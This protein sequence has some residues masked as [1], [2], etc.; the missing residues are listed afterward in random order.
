MRTS[1][2]ERDGVGSS[3][4]TVA[5]S[6]VSGETETR[7]G[8]GTL[9]EIPPHTTPGPLWICGTLI[10]FKDGGESEITVLHQ[11]TK[12]DC[13]F[14]C[15]NTHAVSYS[16]KRPFDRAQCFVMEIQPGKQPNPEPQ[17]TVPQEAE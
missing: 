15:A 10:A 8:S 4:G 7:Q 14:V 17:P 16:G 3:A 2:K 13:E 5:T 11:G 6:T 12:E 1:N 9:R